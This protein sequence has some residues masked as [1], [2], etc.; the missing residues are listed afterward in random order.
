LSYNYASPEM[1]NRTDCGGSAEYY[2]GYVI[3]IAA[4]LDSARSAGNVAGYL[5]IVDAIDDSIAAPPHPDD[6]V[7]GAKSAAGNARALPFQGY[8]QRHPRR[9]P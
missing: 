8:G 1:M 7:S 6:R 5:N 3:A 4:I 9:A 2:R